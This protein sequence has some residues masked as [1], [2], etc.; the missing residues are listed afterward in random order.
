MKPNKDI[1]E[2]KE[3][4]SLHKRHRFLKRHAKNIQQNLFTEFIVFDYNRKIL[5]QVRAKKKEGK[6]C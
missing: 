3:L 2:K 1:N 4:I 5:D 6:I